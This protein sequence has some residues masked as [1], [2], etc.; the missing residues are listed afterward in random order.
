MLKIYILGDKKGSAKRR[1]V[2]LYFLATGTHNEKIDRRFSIG[3][4]YVSS[5]S[6]S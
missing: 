5:C 4:I 6:L 3:W 2:H 1:S